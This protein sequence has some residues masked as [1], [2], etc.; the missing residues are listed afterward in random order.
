MKKYI[1]TLKDLLILLQVYTYIYILYITVGK[2]SLYT[3][4]EVLSGP[5]IRKIKQA[6]Q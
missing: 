1:Y 3:F 6:G 2:K 5:Y 4:L